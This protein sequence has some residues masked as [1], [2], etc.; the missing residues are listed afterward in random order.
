M[1]ERLYKISREKKPGSDEKTSVYAIQ[2]EIFFKILQKDKSILAHFVYRMG[3]VLDAIQH[4][5]FIHSDL[6]PD[7]ILLRMNQSTQKLEEIKLIDFGS[8]FKFDEKMEFSATTPE[9]LSPEMIL[10]L[11]TLK[12]KPD[13][14]AAAA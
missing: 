6:K 3:Q 2:H 14:V 12:N 9:Y 7:N 13:Q 8:S 11:D 1:H 10:Y 5:N 4:V